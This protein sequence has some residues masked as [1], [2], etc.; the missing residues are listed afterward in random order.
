MPKNNLCLK[1]PVRGKCC[2]CATIIEGYNI[3]L[4]NYPCEYLD[5]ETGLCIVYENRKEYIP[6][7]IDTTDNYGKWGYPKECLYIEVVHHPK[8]WLSEVKDKLSKK[9]LKIYDI[10]NDLD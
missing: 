2:Y 6:S 7:C 8:M 9:G 1:C 10:L 4:S 5:L 3:I